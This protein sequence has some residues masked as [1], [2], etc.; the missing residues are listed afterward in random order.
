MHCVVDRNGNYIIGPELH[1]TGR[2]HLYS[3]FGMLN[4]HDS[5]GRWGGIDTAS[6]VIIPFLY[7]SLAENT[8]YN[9]W[10]GPFPVLRAS[11]QG[12]WGLADTAGR[13]LL[14]FAFDEL[15][16]VARVSKRDSLEGWLVRCGKYRGLYDPHGVLVIPCSFDSIYFSYSARLRTGLPV[17]Y[18]GRWGWYRFAGN[19]LIAVRFREP[20]QVSAQFIAGYDDSLKQAVLLSAD[21]GMLASKPYAGFQLWGDSVMAVR[22]DTATKNSHDHYFGRFDLQTMTVTNWHHE[23]YYYQVIE[24]E[25]PRPPERSLQSGL[26]FSGGRQVQAF[27]RDGVSYVPKHMV[28]PR[29]DRYLAR[30]ADFAVV[31]GE[32]A[33]NPRRHYAVVD[34]NLNFIVKPQTGLEIL[35]GDVSNGY[36]IVRRQGEPQRYGVTNLRLRWLVRPQPRYISAFF[37][38]KGKK[39][40]FAARGSVSPEFVDGAPAD[41]YFTVAAANGKIL[42]GFDSVRDASFFSPKEWR[43]KAPQNDIILVRNLYNGN[44]GLIRLNG[45]PAF[46]GI[47]FRF[48]SFDVFSDSIVAG[49][50]SHNKYEVL[51]LD[52]RPVILEL[53]GKLWQVGPSIDNSVFGY[54]ADLAQLKGRLVLLSYHSDNT[55]AGPMAG[56]VYIDRYGTVYADA[57]ALH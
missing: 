52:G 20:P 48:S 50:A 47:Q 1:W 14:P 36:L 10:Y 2:T 23:S 32:S 26:V 22:D 13:V 7:D 29:F 8:E 16:S 41:F 30:A 18:R 21:G 45:T 25:A 34:S 55:G 19:R 42:P 17:R 15:Q 38:W 3:K 54:R 39:Y 27:Q 31:E 53:A 57:A 43:L 6:R 44:Y 33:D 24:M 28:A 37:R 35:G 12:K 9:R 40:L 5:L 4:A 51:F 11:R 49:Q 46:P 56:C